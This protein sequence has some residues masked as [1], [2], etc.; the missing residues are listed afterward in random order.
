MFE[1]F[2]GCFPNVAA[3]FVGYVLCFLFFC[4]CVAVSC[5]VLFFVYV[6]CLQLFVFVYFRVVC[7][8]LFIYGGFIFFLYDYMFIGVLLPKID[9]LVGGLFR[10]H[11]L[12][13][14]E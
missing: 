3:I 14:I 1:G 4:I 8:F 11:V 9:C 7:C 5:F 12:L 6:F 2:Y 13:L 10:L